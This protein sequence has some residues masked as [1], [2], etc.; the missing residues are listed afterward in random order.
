MALWVGLG[1]VAVLG[2][3]QKV[4]PAVEGEC[5]GGKETH[6]DEGVFP[7]EGVADSALF[8]SDD[9]CCREDHREHRADTSG[10]LA[11]EYGTG[12]MRESVGFIASGRNAIHR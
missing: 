4:Y 7:G 11:R 8:L 5:Q 10:V 6:G 3:G 9:P 2:C 1:C 12:E